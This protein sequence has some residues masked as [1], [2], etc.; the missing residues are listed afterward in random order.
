MGTFQADRNST[1]SLVRN[2]NEVRNMMSCIST[3]VHQVQ[4]IN[5]AKARDHKKFSHRLERMMLE[6][7]SG[8]KE[9]RF[10]FEGTKVKRGLRR[11]MS[12]RSAIHLPNRTQ[13]IHFKPFSIAKKM[14]CAWKVCCLIVGTEEEE[15]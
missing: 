11:T 9:I 6:E 15:N 5:H 7:I 10:F 4:C 3:R 8:E 2:F 14:Q 12:S 1:E 13:Q